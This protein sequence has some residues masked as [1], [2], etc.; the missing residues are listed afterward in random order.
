MAGTR[1]DEIQ[2]KRGLKARYL[3][4]RYTLELFKSQPFATQNDGTVASGVGGEVNVMSLGRNLFEYSPKGTQTI[5]VPA[6]VAGGLD[7]GMDQTD[8]DGVELTQGITSRSP[9][10]FTVGTDGPL[11]FSVQLSIEDVSGTDDCLVGFRRA[12]AYQANVDDFTDMAAFNVNNSDILIETILNNAATTTTDTTNNWLDG[13]THTLTVKVSRAG[14]VSY[15]IDG[16]APT[17]V[18]AAFTFDATDVILPMVF[19]LNSSDLV[20][21]VL[22][23]RWECGLGSRSTA[24][25]A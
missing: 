18:P 4:H 20:G 6:L 15:E 2:L 19:L 23:K 25:T 14:L 17:T 5:L 3:E 8:N 11:F 7:I 24:P 13:E 12:A 16:V 10:A 9:G 22:L 21:Q 1:F